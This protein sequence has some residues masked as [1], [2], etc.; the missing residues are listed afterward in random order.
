MYSFSR[1]SLT[2]PHSDS[3]WYN[4]F[5][6]PNFDKKYSYEKNDLGITYSPE[7]TTFKLWA[8]TAKKVSISLYETGNYR[9]KNEKPISINE[10]FYNDSE[11]I[12]ELT[13][14][15]DLNEKYYTYNVE[16]NGEIHES[17]DPYAIACGVNGKRSEILNLKN[18]NPENWENDQHVCY[19]LNKSIIYELH[20]G[21]FSNDIMSGIDEKYRGKFMAFTIKN[22]VFNNDEKKPTCLNYLKK[23][24]ITTVHLMP[25]FDFE[26]VEEDYLLI[27]NDESLMDANFNWGYD[28]EN[29][30]C[31][32]GSYSTNPY[33]GKIRIIEFKKMIQ[34]LHEENISVIMDVVYNH[35]YRVYFSN[36]EKTVPFYYYRQLPN[37]DKSGGSG[38]YNDTASERK[39]VHNYIVNSVLYWAKE[40]HIDGFRFDLMGLHDLDLMTDIRNKLNEEIPNGK[41]IIMYGEPWESGTSISVKGFTTPMANK[42][43]ISLFPKGISIFHDEL[44]DAIKGNVFDK[45][46]KGFISGNIIENPNEAKRITEDFRNY[47][48]GGINGV[49]NQIKNDR[50][51]NYMSCHDNNTLYDK[52]VIAEYQLQEEKIERPKRPKTLKGIENEEIYIHPQKLKSYKDKSKF[53]KKNEI[54]VQRNKLGAAILFLSF[55]VPFFQAG[56]EGGRTKFGEGNSYNLAKSVNML[57]WERIYEFQD[58]V[59]YYRKLIKLRK[60]L[61]NIYDLNK[62]SYFNLEGLPD[63]IIGFIVQRMKYGKYKEIIIIFNSTKN[64][65]VYKFTFGGKW[66]ILLSDELTKNSIIT[67]KMFT[68]NAI[69]AGV[70]GLLDPNYKPEK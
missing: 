58:L 36:F 65:F 20:V 38:C 41:E 14:K 52:L 70:I 44:R 66:K 53:I 23:L 50:L 10:M 64:G 57:N 13:I 21:D 27:K 68:V 4:Y 47:F 16:A 33:D 40:Y 19:P 12:W 24:G 48:T 55:G 28:P 25:V 1:E 51:I 2:K 11:N 26:S 31:P 56:E 60:I 62:M 39:M 37:G 42:K 17:G 59:D 69:S 7:E 49:S 15:Q 22:S 3:E 34:S 45:T 67:N 54:I 61:G 29:Y 43:S 5:S 18:T 30:N 8:P 63:G 46:G 32:E 6:D 35:T 9:N